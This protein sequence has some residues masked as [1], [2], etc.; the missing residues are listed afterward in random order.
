MDTVDSNMEKILKLF[1][2]AETKMN[3][4]PVGFF[5]TL[6]NLWFLVLMLFMRA[7]NYLKIWIS[8][9]SYI[10]FSWGIQE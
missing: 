4:D 6:T 5:T 7:E 3:G 1:L 10:S 2:K 8:K 9:K